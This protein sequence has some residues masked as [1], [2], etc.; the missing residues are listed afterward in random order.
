[1]LPRIHTPRSTT[2]DA[3]RATLVTIGQDRS[4]ALLRAAGEW[5]LANAEQ[6]GE[7]LDEQVRAGRRLVRLDVSAVTFIDCACLEVLTGAHRRLL[8]ARGTLVLTGV[9][10]RMSR[11]L[12][13]AGLDGVLL[14]TEVSDI[15]ARSDRVLMRARKSTVPSVLHTA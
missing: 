12:H 5:D 2:P 7:L 10:A 13:A 1:M 3:R 11:L 9:P 8:A 14:T 4:R 15:D 6:L